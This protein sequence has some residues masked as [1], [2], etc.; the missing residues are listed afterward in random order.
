MVGAYVRKG[1]E[2][3]EPLDFPESPSRPRDASRTGRSG[4]EERA[5][6]ERRRA[7]RER[8]QNSA[9]S[10]EKCERSGVAVLGGG[11]L[12]A[13]LRGLGD[14]SLYRVDVADGAGVSG[15]RH[16]GVGAEGGGDDAFP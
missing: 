10:A 6:P 13:A 4:C 12:G 1:D 9:L 16:R 8:L 3:D 14:G 5:E 11:G 15:G 2:R 7:I